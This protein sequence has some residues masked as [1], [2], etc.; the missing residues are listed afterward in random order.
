MF[1]NLLLDKN[2]KE[3]LL[4]GNSG[5]PLFVG[6]NRLEQFALGY[7]PWHWHDEIQFSIVTEGSVL[8]QSQGEQYTLYAGEGVFI[9]SGFLHM[10]KPKSPDGTYIC[11]DAD[12]KLISSFPG[13]MIEETYFR[14]F[15]GSERMA[16]IPLYPD[17]AWS[18]SILDDIMKVYNC[19]IEKEYGHELQIS[20]ILM[21]VWEG[22]LKSD[23]GSRNFPTYLDV[24]QRM[25]KDIITYIENHYTEKITLDDILSDI[26]L[27]KGECCRAFKR[28]ANIT[29]FEYLIAYRIQKSAELLT[30]TA[31]TIS[32][33]ALSVGFSN[34]SYFTEIFKK[35]TNQ[36]PSEY[37]LSRSVFI[38]K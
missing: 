22:L 19:F 21:R 3:T 18:A 26:H 37:R 31:M 38:D 27:S 15:I 6:E 16:V 8:F 9:N 35:H 20:A 10:T 23:A 1:R 2:N 25:M 5:F 33:I 36:T 24:G 34:S 28:N 12:T 32:Q 17:K 11:I 29:I 30:G 13:S 7:V 4:F 14:P